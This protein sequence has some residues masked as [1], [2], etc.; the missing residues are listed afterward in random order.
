MP[1]MKKSL[2]S[3][4]TPCFNEAENIEDCY[5]AVREA[6]RPLEDSGRYQFEHIFIDNASSDNTRQIVLDI[7]KV[8]K[9]IRYFRNNRNVGSIN[10]IWLGLNIAKGDL[11]VP[12]I[13]ADLQDPPELIPEFVRNWELG[14]LVIQGIAKKREEGVFLRTLRRIF[15]FVIAKLS[16]TYLPSGANEFCAIDRRVVNAVLETDDKKPYIRGLIH[17]VGC[18]TKYLHYY[19]KARVKGV[20]KESLTSYF[21]ISLNALVSTSIL[22]P[23]VLLV[24]GIGTSLISTLIGISVAGASFAREGT[25][26]LFQTHNL[27]WGIFLLLGLQT[28]FLGIICEYIVSIHNQVRPKPKSFFVEK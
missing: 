15:Y 5:L 26:G 7:K 2:I 12:L 1:K 6:I 24:F 4:I 14:Y 22:F 25:T 27:I 16:T 19:K 3:I 18:D 23:R 21:D 11:V 20:S 17:L 10:N 9:K 13:P 8:D 28:L